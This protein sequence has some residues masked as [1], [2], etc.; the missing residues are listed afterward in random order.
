MLA[1]LVAVHWVAKIRSTK[2]DAWTVK[3]WS[4]I[5]QYSH[6]WLESLQMEETREETQNV[7]SLLTLFVE[8]N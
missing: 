2:G 5:M 7:Q 4:Q 1:K 6:R 3:L 8:V